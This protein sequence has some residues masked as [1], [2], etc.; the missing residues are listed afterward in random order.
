[1]PPILEAEE[2]DTNS[3]GQSGKVD[4]RPWPQDCASHDLSAHRTF[5]FLE[6]NKDPVRFSHLHKSNLTPTRRKQVCQKLVR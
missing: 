5:Q 2:L 4:T 3:E 6:R 1:M